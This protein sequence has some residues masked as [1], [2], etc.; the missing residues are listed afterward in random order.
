L[1]AG[2]QEETGPFT[3]VSIKQTGLVPA[4]AQSIRFSGIAGFPLPSRFTVSLDGQNLPWATLEQ[5]G[6]V[7]LFAADVSAFAGRV[8]ELRFSSAPDQPFFLDAISFSPVAVPEPSSWALMGAGLL[9][10]AAFIRKR[11]CAERP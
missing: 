10:L 3:P 1:I 7:G 5:N 2:F 8:A 6:S 9:C 11:A 4:D